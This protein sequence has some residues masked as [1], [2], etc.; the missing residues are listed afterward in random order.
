M[1]FISTVLRALRDHYTPTPKWM[2]ALKSPSRLYKRNQMK[3]MGAKYSGRSRNCY[4]LGVLRSLRAMRYST[5]GLESKEETLDR[6][7]ETRITAACLEHGMDKNYFLTSLAEND[8][9]LNRETLSNLAIYE[10]RTFQSLVQFVKERSEEIGLQSKKLGYV[11]GTETR[12][13]LDEVRKHRWNRGD[14]V[15]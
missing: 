1:V 12:G 13:I 10:P 9:N 2:F 11:Y 7:Y 15:D 5:K 6:L 3:R 14:E 8:I 4:I